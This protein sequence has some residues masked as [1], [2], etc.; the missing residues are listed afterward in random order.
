MELYI[1]SSY[2]PSWHGRGKLYVLHLLGRQ[3]KNA[4]L[5]AV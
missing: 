4:M 5:D 2:V 1:Y 3:N